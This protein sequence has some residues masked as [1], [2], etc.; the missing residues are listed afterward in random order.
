LSFVEGGVDGISTE[1]LDGMA[2]EIRGG[3]AVLRVLVASDT[4]DVSLAPFCSTFEKMKFPSV[5]ITDLDL[6]LEKA[7]DRGTPVC[8]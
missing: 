3:G 8:P 7:I 6:R 5:L 1:A 2:L 4:F